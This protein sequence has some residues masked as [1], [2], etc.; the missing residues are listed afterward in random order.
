MDHVYAS[1]MGVHHYDLVSQAKVKK[2]V[3]YF[4]G[5]VSSDFRCSTFLHIADMFSEDLRSLT[6]VARFH[7]CTSTQVF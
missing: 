2:N 1:V 7:Y 6:R 4:L 3:S 5:L